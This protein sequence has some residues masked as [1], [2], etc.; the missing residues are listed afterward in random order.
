MFQELINQ[1]RDRIRQ[2]FEARINLIKLN[3][4]GQAAGLMSNLIFLFICLFIFFC[5][6]LFCGLGLVEV[7]NDWGLSRAASFFVTIGVYLL[8]LILALVFRKGITEF[9]AGKFI[10]V[11]TANDN[12]PDNEKENSATGKS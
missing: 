10:A 4:I 9:F 6:L 3:L 5:I 11:M 1:I 12:T 8:V 7:F 2:Y